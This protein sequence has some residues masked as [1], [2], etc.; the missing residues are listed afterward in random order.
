[1][2]TYKDKG[3]GHI[4]QEIALFVQYKMRQ[5]FNGLCRGYFSNELSPKDD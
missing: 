3:Q 5:S 4:G 2:R 1:M